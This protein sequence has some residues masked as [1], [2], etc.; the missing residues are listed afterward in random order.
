MQEFLYVRIFKV[1]SLSDLFHGS[2]LQYEIFKVEV[3]RKQGMQF[4]PGSQFDPFCRNYVRLY[5][6]CTIQVKNKMS[7]VYFVTNSFSLFFHKSSDSCTHA[8]PSVDNC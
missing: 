1:Q 5:I 3:C 2:F 8:S 6:S 7:G 4:D